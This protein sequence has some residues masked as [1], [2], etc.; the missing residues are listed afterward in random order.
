MDIPPEIISGEAGIC[1]LQAMLAVAYIY[2]ANQRWSGWNDQVDPMAAWVSIF[3]PVMPNP[4][5]SAKF[6]FSISDLK[7]GPVQDIIKSRGPP[8][9][10]FECEAGLALVAF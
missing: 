8:I 6:L 2:Q 5:P 9:A 1:T 3:W 7:R 10:I 4:A